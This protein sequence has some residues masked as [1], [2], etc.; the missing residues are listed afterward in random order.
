MK[1]YCEDTVMTETI[2]IKE[3][4]SAHPEM[5]NSPVAEEYDDNTEALRQEMPGDT[6]CYFNNESFATGSYVKSGTLMLKCD[7]G[8]WVPSIS[9][10]PDNL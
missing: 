1:V 5:K 10:D 3:V 4:G 9:A 7:Y 6:V 8:I 2:G